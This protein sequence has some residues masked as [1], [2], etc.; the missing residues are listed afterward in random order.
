MN[1]KTAVRPKLAG[2]ARA[3]KVRASKAAT[4]RRSAARHRAKIEA[5]FDELA[6]ERLADLWQGLYPF[7]IDPDCE[8]PDRQG[9]IEDLVDFGHVLQPNSDGMTADQLCWLIGKCGR[10]CKTTAQAHEHLRESPYCSFRKACR[11]YRHG[12]VIRAG[13]ELL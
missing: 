12:S 1:T 2:M 9:I 5:L 10:A 13:C 6:T 3:N 7:P 11:Q 4:G 8:L